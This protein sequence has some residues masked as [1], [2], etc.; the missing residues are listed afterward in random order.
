MRTLDRTLDQLKK[1]TDE[2]AR[3]FDTHQHVRDE[4]LSGLPNVDMEAVL[5]ESR[6]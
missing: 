4:A 2:T 3:V 5:E 6:K 1:D